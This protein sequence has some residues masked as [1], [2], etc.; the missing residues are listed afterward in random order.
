[1]MNLATQ[2][3]HTA[4]L[5]WNGVNKFRTKVPLSIEM[6]PYTVKTAETKEE[7]LE[8]FRLRHEVFHKEFR[9]VNYDGLDFDRFDFVYDHL[10]IMHNETQ[11]IIGTYRLNCSETIKHSYTGLEFKLEAMETVKGPYLELGRACIH[12]KYRKGSVIFLLWRGIAEYMK[13]SGA[14]L[15]FGCS[16]LKVSNAREAALIYR[17]LEENGHVRENGNCRPT[18]KFR[19]KDFSSWYA[20]FAHLTDSQKEEVKDLI[21]SL[22]K[23]YLKLGAKV[24]AEPAFDREFNCIDLLTFLPKDSLDASLANKFKLTR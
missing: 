20:Y 2:L 1:M 5:K 11:Q 23:S 3:R 4:R 13:Q 6:G 17:Y 21:P 10:I 16:S 12:R 9:G 19:M 8:S 14:N 15:L 18:R 24:A 22:L 7:L